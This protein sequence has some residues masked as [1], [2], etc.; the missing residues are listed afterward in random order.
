[1]SERYTRF[2]ELLSLMKSTHDS[3][4]KDY[5]GNG[6]PYANIRAA[7]DWGMGSWK[8]AMMRADEKMRRLKSFAQTGT[9]SNESA[10]DSLLD[11]AV[12]SLIGYVLLEEESKTSSAS[13]PAPLPR[14]SALRAQEYIRQRDST[15]PDLNNGCNRQLPGVPHGALC[16]AAEQP[17]TDDW[18]NPR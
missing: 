16:Q 18:Y 10:Y 2:D 4:G 6:K 13:S 14:L 3:K 12:L 1:M 11:I 8:Y 15:A 7:E 17:C 9:L 5:E